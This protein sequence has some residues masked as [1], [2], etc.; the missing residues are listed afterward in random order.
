[1]HVVEDMN[2]IA[3]HCL[4]FM[5]IFLSVQFLPATEDHLY[6]IDGLSAETNYTIKIKSQTLAG[7]SK[8]TSS[9][10]ISTLNKGNYVYK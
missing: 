5:F 6:R 8:I 3:L 9:H 1:M 4:F 7:Q 10:S 2:H